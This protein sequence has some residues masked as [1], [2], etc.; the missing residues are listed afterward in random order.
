MWGKGRE[1]EGGTPC[2]AA[3]APCLCIYPRVEL[4]SPFLGLWK[5]SA[6]HGAHRWNQLKQKVANAP[7]WRSQKHLALKARCFYFFFALRSLH[8]SFSDAGRFLLLLP[9]LP[10][11]TTGSVLRL[12]I[13]AIVFPTS[14]QLLE[15]G[16]A[17]V[18]IQN[19]TA[20]VVFSSPVAASQQETK[21]PPLQRW[22]PNYYS[23]LC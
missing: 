1:G 4:G 20:I 2:R 22:L 13:Q 14:S 6:T 11:H 7:T 15:L 16:R 17:L 5:G 12:N 19:V 18:L 10:S 23:L 21:E 8:L 3:P 9:S